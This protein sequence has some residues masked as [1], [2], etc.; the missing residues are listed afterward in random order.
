MAGRKV[1]MDARWT[2]H[3][4]DMCPTHAATLTA[5]ILTIPIYL[6]SAYNSLTINPVTIKDPS[7]LLFQITFQNNA[8][9]KK[10]SSD[11]VFSPTI[12]CS[13]GMWENGL[14]FI[15]KKNIKN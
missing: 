1:D 12:F 4:M 15:Y 7:T 11:K 6:L 13:L 8:D 3:Q 10:S 2:V 14:L 5:A 9:Q